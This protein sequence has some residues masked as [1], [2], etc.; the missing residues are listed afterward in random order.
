[1]IV[2]YF[3]GRVVTVPNNKVFGSENRHMS[4]EYNTFKTGKQSIKGVF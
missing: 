1:V 3:P 2:R 4:N